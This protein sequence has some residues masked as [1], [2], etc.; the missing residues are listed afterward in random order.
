MIE[1]FQFLRPAWLLALL[2]LAGLVWL[3]LK[4]KNTS[5]SWQSVVDPELLRHLLVGNT[6]ARHSWPIVVIAMVGFFTVVALAGPVWEKLPRPIFKQ[7]AALV[8]ALD[9]SRSMDANDIKPSR[10][11]RARH[12]IADIL[13]QR[14]EG[15]TAL[16]AYAADAFVV[17]PL[18]EDSATINALLPALTT[19]IMP[20][21]GG[22]ADRAVKQALELFSNAGA[23]HGDVLIVTDGFSTTEVVEIERLVRENPGFRISVLGIGSEA[24]GPVPL[25]SGGF[26]KDSQGAIVVSRMPVGMMRALANKG[27]GEFQ[28]I[29]TDDSDIQAFLKKMQSNPFVTEAVAS[30]QRADIWRE[31]GPWLVLLLLPVIALA[32]RRGVLMIL[33]LLLLPFPPDA[34]ALGWDEMWQ[35]RNQRGTLLFDQGAHEQAAKLFDRSDWKA[36]SLYRAGK[37]DEALQLWKSDESEDSRYNRANALAKMGQYED[38]IKAYQQVLDLN[39][40]HQDATYNKQLLEEILKQQ[41]QQQQEQQQQQQNQANNDSQQSDQSSQEQNNS[42]EQQEAQSGSDESQAERQSEQDSTDQNSETEQ[43]EAAETQAAQ[44]EQ[45]QSNEE[46][47]EQAEVDSD[48]DEKMS[49]Q[50]ANQW[51]RKIPDDPGGLLRRKFIYQYKNRGR[52]AEEL[53]QW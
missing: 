47:V 11:T 33:P 23:V 10:L 25:A 8:I 17:T 15:Q 12:K 38:A 1:Q 41:Q 7:Q 48:V 19:D 42:A 51:L 27:S 14:A 29:S 35:N 53:N 46:G 43:Q 13:S 22:R 32:F 40:Q 44:S 52:S 26:L 49:E 34:D 9:S 30:D 37:Y 16:I 20:A 24:G 50:A 18:T 39:P 2:P 21:Q 36:S 4:S 28:T 45:A 5:G 6:Q 3:M 31:Q